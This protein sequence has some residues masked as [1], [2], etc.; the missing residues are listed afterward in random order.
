MVIMKTIVA[1]KYFI[2]EDKKSRLQNHI[3]ATIS[4]F[5]YN[6]LAYPIIFEKTEY[7]Y[8]EQTN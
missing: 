4:P 2:W 7:I 8:F 5:D 3:R 1:I 6:L